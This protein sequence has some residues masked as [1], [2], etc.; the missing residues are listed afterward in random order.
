VTAVA[1][2]DAVSHTVESWVTRA[3]N[4]VSS[5]L[6]R[7]AWK[8]LSGA[9]ERVIEPSAGA[10][11]RGEMLLGAHLAGAAVEASM[12]GAAH[13]AA[14]PLTAR[15]PMLA[16]GEAVML[17]LPHVVRFNEP[18][19]PL[20]ASLEEETLPPRQAAE[21]LAERLESWRRRGGLPQRLR[22]AG[23]PR[24]TLASLAAEAAEQWTGRF[25]PRPLEPA[26]FEDLYDAAW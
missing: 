17:M 9:W 16:H 1:G 3:R 7:E 18:A 15:D 12:L 20:Y 22:D 2:L 11:A 25:N 19:W 26:D 23:V 21:A 14:N 5:L 8:L 4:P 6:A 10:G 13:A 24:G